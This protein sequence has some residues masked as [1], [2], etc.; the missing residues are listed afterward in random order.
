MR[1]QNAQSQILGL[2]ERLRICQISQILT[3]VF[4]S[5]PGLWARNQ[6]ARNTYENDFLVKIFLEVLVAEFLVAMIAVSLVLKVRKLKFGPREDDGLL[7][8][9]IA[10]I[11]FVSA[12]LLAQIVIL[13][14]PL[15]TLAIGVYNLYIAQQKILDLKLTTD[16]TDMST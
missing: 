1:L 7:M 15:A 8:L 3:I 4:A 13:L 5:I 10:L 14:L 6:I 11:T 16:E 9:L 12:I 2:T